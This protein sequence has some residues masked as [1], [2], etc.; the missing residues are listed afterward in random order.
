MRRNLLGQVIPALLLLLHFPMLSLAQ[1][2]SVTLEQV[3]QCTI[4][5]GC[6]RLEN[7]RPSGLE[8]ESARQA[9]YLGRRRAVIYC[10]A[11]DKL[12]GRRW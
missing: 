5:V 4:L 7:G 11:A 2:P 6:D 10:A 8:R 1:Q 9:K 3:L 12:Y